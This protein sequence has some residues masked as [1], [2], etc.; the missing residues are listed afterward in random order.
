TGSAEQGGRRLVMVLAGLHS[1]NERI[2]ESVKFM[3][4]GFRAWQPRPIAPK[5][6]KVGTADVQL[7]TANHVGLVAPRDLSVVVPSG[8]SPE[9]QV[10]V[11]YD[12]PVK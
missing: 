6:K 4:W 9:M 7:G 12:G 11:A 8:T 2:D 10:K 1:F 5:G 3:N